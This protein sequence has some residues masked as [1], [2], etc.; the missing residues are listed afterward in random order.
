MA[1]IFLLNI[2]APGCHPQ[3]IFQVKDLDAQHR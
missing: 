1:D 3:G 2:S